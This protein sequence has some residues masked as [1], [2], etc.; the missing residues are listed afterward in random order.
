MLVTLIFLLELVQLHASLGGLF[1]PCR[2]FAYQW[3]ISYANGFTRRGLLGSLLRMLHL[4]NGNYLLIA[5]CGW[6][7]T[8]ALFSLLVGVLLRLLAPLEPLTRTV[9][10]IALLLSPATVGLLVLATGDPLQPILVIYVAL[11]L[12]LLRPGNSITVPIV[13]FAVFGAASILVHEASI[14]LLGPTLLLAAFFARRS[15]I[16]RAALFGYLLGAVPT[17]LLVIHFTENHSIAAV[18]P[19]HFG[20]TAITPPDKIL[21]GTFSSLLAQENATHFHHG[22]QGYLLMARNAVGALLLPLF[23]SL[24]VGHLLPQSLR[25]SRATRRGCTFAFL[26]PLL[27]SAPLW[28]IAMDWGRFSSYLFILT[29]TVLSLNTSEAAVPHTALQE[30]KLPGFLIGTL[31]VLSGMTT[32]RALDTYVIKGLGSDNPTLIAALLLC[33]MGA[34]VLFLQTRRNTVQEPQWQ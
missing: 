27:L 24:V 16:D 25:G 9:L 31:P 23:L 11:T 12:F 29:L 13:T 26:V 34:R 22:I 33:V 2:Y 4:D 17:L 10:L 1:G 19:M 30:R 6:L 8:L 7:I 5:V 28:I 15:R 21:L 18:A 3:S 14:F 20:A 32:T